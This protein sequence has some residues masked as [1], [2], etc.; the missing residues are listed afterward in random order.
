MARDPAIETGPQGAGTGLG[1]GGL[2]LFVKRWASD[3]RRIGAILPSAKRLARLMARASREARYGAGPVVELG[4]GTGSITRALLASGIAEEELVLV[5]RDRQLCRWL[6][7]RFPGAVVIEGEAARIGALLG[8]QAV[9]TP[10]VMVSSLPLRNLEEDERDAIIQE[11]LDVL[12]PA[13]AVVQFTYGRHPAIAGARLGV[14]CQRIG[15]VPLNVPPASVWRIQRL[16]GRTG[17]H[18]SQTHLARRRFQP[19]GRAQPATRL[20]PR[21]G[22]LLL[23]PGTRYR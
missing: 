23:R 11:S 18:R 8:K 14:E 4:P 19:S 3:P 9:G 21:L 15:F 16:Q 6:E 22:G 2:G 13:G 5:E 20:V 12:P 7:H 10:S 17:R 1:G